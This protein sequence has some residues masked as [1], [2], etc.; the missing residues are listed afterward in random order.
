MRVRAFDSRA[1]MGKAR[2]IGHAPRKKVRGDFVGRAK[3][4]TVPTVSIG[5]PVRP[6][7]VGLRQLCG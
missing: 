2:E 1:T 6:K 5:E 7:K 4:A 3:V